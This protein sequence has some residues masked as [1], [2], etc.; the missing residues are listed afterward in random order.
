[1]TKPMPAVQTAARGQNASPVHQ[2]I[3]SAPK[4][5]NASAMG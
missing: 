4:V 3:A 2:N 1:M 5:R